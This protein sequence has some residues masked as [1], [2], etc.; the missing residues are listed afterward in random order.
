MATEYQLI[1]NTTGQ[2][3][4][5]LVRYSYFGEKGSSSLLSS[6]ALTDPPKMPIANDI[7]IPIIGL[8]LHHQFMMTFDHQNASSF[9]ES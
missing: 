7:V 8:S 3:N 5:R 2:N 9:K 6:K 1:M 4:L